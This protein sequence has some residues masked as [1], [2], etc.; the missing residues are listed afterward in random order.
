MP[1]PALSNEEE[2]YWLALKMVPGLGT[3]RAAQLGENFRSA[4][5]I[6]RASRSDLEAVGLPGSVAQS[7]ASGCTFEDAVDQQ[8]RMRATDTRLICFNDAVYPP[9]LRQI[10]DPPQVLF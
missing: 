6:F 10:F 7:I 4:E 9:L 3:R 2:L 5:S 8:T 1:A